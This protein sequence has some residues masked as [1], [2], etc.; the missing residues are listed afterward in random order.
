LIAVLGFALLPNKIEDTRW[1]TQKEKELAIRRISRDTVKESTNTSTWENFK[2]VLKDRRM[3]IFMLMQFCHLAACGFTNFYPSLMLSISDG[4]SHKALAYA[5]GPFALAVP[6][7]LLVG[8]SS[9]KYNERKWHIT[10]P[11]GI[12]IVGFS[13]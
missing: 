4:D 7:V 10:I 2:L 9:G 1:L 5:A 8:A 12:A 3:W 11:M 6:I 13:K